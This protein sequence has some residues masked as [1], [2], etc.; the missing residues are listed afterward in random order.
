MSLF[1]KIISI[2]ILFVATSVAQ[3]QNPYII[4]PEFRKNNLPF[5]LEEEIPLN[6]PKIALALSGGSARGLAQIGVL[7]ALEE[8]GI[9]IDMIVGTSMGSIIGGLYAAG[10]SVS[11]LDSIARNTNWD[12]LLSP[13]G[14]TDRRELFIDQ[15]ITEDK[16]IL[17][18]RLDGLSPIIPTSINTGHR[19]SNYLN[20]LTLQAPVHVENNF[21]D[22]RIKFRA[23]CTDLVTGEAVVLDKGSLS[24]A[25][26]ASSSVS[27]FLSPVKMDSMI[28]VDGGLVANI[29]VKIATEMGADIVIAVNTTS[30]LHSREELALPWIIADQIVSIP[31]KLL[32]ENQLS[33]ADF[34]IAPPNPERSPTDF[35]NID[36]LIL[37]GYR[38]TFKQIGA[39]KHK[40]DLATNQTYSGTEKYFKNIKN[41]NSPFQWEI[42]LLEKYASEDSISASQIEHD[43][44][45]V[46][47]KE[48]VKNL[49]ATV[50]EE[51][52]YTEIILTPDFNPVIKKVECSGISILHKTKIDSTTQ[53][54]IGKVYNGPAVYLL[55]RDILN[56]YRV[57]GYSLATLKEQKFD[58]YAGR[59]SLSFEEGIISGISV[60]G[61]ENTNRN[62]ITREFPIKAGDYF[63]YRQIEKGLTNLR[64][65][66]LFE[67]LI[68][69]VKKKDDRNIVVLNVHEKTSGLLRM[70]FRVD[71]ERKAQFSLDIRDENLFGSGTELGL[72]LFGGTRNRAYILE[73]KSNRIFDTYL[74]YKINAYYQLQNIF[75]Y[76]NSPTTSDRRFSR[77]NDG[78]YRQIFYGASVAVGTQVEKFGNLIFKGKYQF[79]EVK[80]IDG[81]PKSP[82][83]IKVVSLKIGSTIDSQDRYPYPSSGVYFDGSYESASS[84]LG[85]DVGFTNIGFLYKSYFTINDIHTFSPKIMMGFGDKTLPLSE[86]Y[87][88]GGQN[89]FFGMRENEYRGRQIFLS[90]LSYRVQL[91]LQIFF[92]AYFSVRYDLGSIWDFQEQIRFKDLKQGIGATLSF[93]TPVGPADFSVGRSFLYKKNLPDNPISWGDINFYFS[94]G[95]FY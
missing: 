1:S 47:E 71:D 86:Q 48:K 83:K 7:K 28:L 94:I 74:T 60:E 21:D 44:Y 41:H 78:E 37:N 64:S 56:L 19:L 79:D 3:A 61:N 30:D 34:V 57:Q 42:S 51:G 29:P 73:L 75:V 40:I 93:D 49:T 2:A 63:H 68:L 80:N 81:S 33:G 15:K 20:L 72:L 27:F 10:Y 26:R 35:T 69:T 62:V 55:V 77:I 92:D 36:L 65:T 85:G 89:S 38:S 14:E 46:C 31:M 67:D 6:R 87:S 23:V 25:M 9:H 50:S 11:Q 32:N 8:A 88:L 39:I 18:L 82:Y 84:F 43:L 4:K 16:A 90:S 53:T 24:Q 54:A 95:Y 45:S 70:G 66:N 17:T 13:E 52:K 59:L 22:F 5:G 91:P 12:E 58:E 76:K